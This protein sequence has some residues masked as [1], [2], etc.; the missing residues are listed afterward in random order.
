VETRTGYQ[1]SERISKLRERALSQ[2]DDIFLP[3]F[4]PYYYL[5]GWMSEPNAPLPVRNAAALCNVIDKMPLVMVPGEI[6]VG[7]NG[8]HQFDGF[9]N[10]SIPDPAAWNEPIA[11]SNLSDEQK[12]RMTQWLGDDPFG[13]QRLSSVAPKPRE[14]QIAEEHGVVSVWGGDIN[15]SIRAYEKVLRL[16]FSGIQAEVESSLAALAPADPDAAPRRANLLA[17]KAICESAKG[18]GARHAA[19]A[20]EMA[21]SCADADQQAEWQR[22]A[23][24]CEQVPAQPA[25]TFREA[26]Q[27]LWLAHVITVWEDGINANGIGR[28]DQFLWP[29]LERDLADGTITAHAAE[30]I[31]AALW[32]KLYRPYDV[33]QM[34]IGGQLD[35]GGDAT[36]PLSY[37]VLDVTEGLGFV[38]CLSARLHRQSPRRFIARCVDLLAVGGGIP[39][40]FNDEA[41]IPAL[42]SHGI[43]LEDARGY[44]AIGCIEITIP[45][46]ANPHA[47]SHWINLAKVLE[48][49]LNDG[50]DLLDGAQL[51]PRTGSLSDFSSIDDVMA[52][53]TKQ[54][55]YFAEWSVYGSNAAEIAHR[56]QYRLPYLSL[57]TD[58]CVS[59]GMDIIEGG[60]R[61]NY[62]S[63]AAMGIPNAADSLAALQSAVFTD[64]IIS[65][66]DMLE[67]LRANFAGSED[68]RLMLRNRLPKY[69][70][71]QPLPDGFASQLAG[72]Y[73]ELLARYSTPSG[74]SFFSHLFTFVLMLS[75]G[76]L[77]GASPEGRLAGEPLAYSVSP[78]QGRDKEG[79]TAAL[80]SLAKIPHHLAAASSSAILEVTPSLLNEDGREAFVALLIAAIGKG[81][82]QLQFNVVSADTLKAAQDD[83]DRY[84][85]LCVRV[86]G[87]SQRFCLLDREMQE[88]I[89]ARTKHAR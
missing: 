19:M 54:L 31:L 80:N 25:R 22:I 67:A 72:Q 49:A 12:A 5:E 15:H 18:L 58:D 64:K 55:E 45:G 24:I 66:G 62:H 39:F 38:R 84:S 77:T 59:R 42:M 73:C 53:Y 56:S 14:L 32:I 33:Q 26:V 89:I 13:Y 70:N 7:E 81:V 82:G 36:N 50:C 11:A 23:D 37:L 8:D 68:L 57:L 76:K 4:R 2:P 43:P 83:P 40:F 63:S 44:A 35:D 46:K 65:P 3:V 16:G 51:G 75:H 69:G 78:A 21:A 6:I 1:P 61:Y 74:G 87:F 85:N 48:L 28:I 30:D 60:A 9:I 34:M 71:D 27:S 47:V 10:L 20:R 17:F 41:L 86:S 29:Y 79:I 88:H 52:A